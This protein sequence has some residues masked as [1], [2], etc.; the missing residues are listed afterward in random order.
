MRPVF[1]LEHPE[2][3][4]V[5]GA[6]TELLPDELACEG[7][8]FREHAVLRIVPAQRHFFSPQLELE[9]QRPDPDDEYA[10]AS[11]RLSGRFAPHPHVWTLFVAIYGLIAIGAT[12][13]AMWGLAQWILGQPPW[14]L[15]AVPA[16]LA[17][18]AFVYGAAFIGQ[19]LGAEQMYLLRSL[20]DRAVSRTAGQ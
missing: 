8:V 9:A 5:L 19:G 14:T 15:L 17:L 18:A 10:P 1:A 16:G 6:L 11:A 2:P 12:A 3:T 20:V 13:G 4:A 7:M